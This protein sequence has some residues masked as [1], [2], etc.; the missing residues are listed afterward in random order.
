[1]YNLEDLHEISKWEQGVLIENL[2]GDTNL[3]HFSFLTEQNKYK[4]TDRN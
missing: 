1:M 3:Q 4:A 2:E